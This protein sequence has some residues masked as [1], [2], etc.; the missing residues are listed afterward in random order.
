MESLTAKFKDYYGTGEVRGLKVEES[1]NQV[2]GRLMPLLDRSNR[3][4][5]RNLK[6]LK[7]WH[8]PP[9]PSVNVGRAEQVNVGAQQVNVTH[10]MEGSDG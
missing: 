1:V 8:Q 2:V 3:M 10:K 7:E 9:L 4:M 5:L 6:G